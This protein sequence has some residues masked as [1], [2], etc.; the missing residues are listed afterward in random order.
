ML[1]ETHTHATTKS[2]GRMRVFIMMGCAQPPNF[3][4]LTGGKVTTLI[5]NRLR[6]YH[7]LGSLLLPQSTPKKKLMTL[8]SND[9]AKQ[10]APAS[11]STF[12]DGYDKSHSVCVCHFI[13][14]IPDFNL[15]LPQLPD[16]V[17]T[18]LRL[19]YDAEADAGSPSSPRI[20]TSRDPYNIGHGLKTDAEIAEL[21]RRKRGKLANHYQRQNDVRISLP[22]FV[23]IY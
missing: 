3:R 10:K 22:C 5:C 4:N 8:G 2:A 21:R 1:H 18:D 17:V 13:F 23:V 11:H 7:S 6:T 16:A 14:L 9:N 12:S 15:A 20:A 19:Q